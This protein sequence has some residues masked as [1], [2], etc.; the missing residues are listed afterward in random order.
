MPITATVTRGFTY[1]T[2]VEVSS[3]SLNRLGEPT[4][5]IPS[6]SA[7]E[8]VA[9]LAIM[10]IAITFLLLIAFILFP[11]FHYL[12]CYFYCFNLSLF[13][14]LLH[15]KNYFAPTNVGFTGAGRLVSASQRLRISS[16][17]PPKLNSAL[18][19]PRAAINSA[20]SLS[21]AAWSTV[22]SA[23]ITTP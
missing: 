19:S 9:R 4:V 23:A 11:L 15:L 18:L 6:I 12:C 2:G 20:R 13:I 8:V 22:P 21:V 16:R 1:D 7:T 3:A 10:A 14:F 5:T 17:S